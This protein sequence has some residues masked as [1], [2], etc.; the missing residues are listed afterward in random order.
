MVALDLR[1]GGIFHYRMR[2]PDGQDM[3][4]RWLIR[5]VVEPEKLVFVSSFSDE[6]GV[7]TRH[8]LHA[9]WPLQ[10]LSTIT[11]AELQEKSLLTVQWLPV[12]ATELERKTFDEGH[13]SMQQGWTG[14]LD[15]LADY[16]SSYSTS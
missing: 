14:T 16:L 7:L 3:W 11:F 4:G 13:D 10:V 8:P 6:A 5:Q 15:R 2:M 12:N 1:P 9:S